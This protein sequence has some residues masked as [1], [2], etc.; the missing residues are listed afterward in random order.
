MKKGVYLIL[1]LLVCFWLT[2]PVAAE[3]GCS[4]TLSL[5]VGELPVT[6]GSFTLY[7]V[8]SESS[9]GYRIREE[10]GGGFVREEDAL[11]PHLAQWMERY[12]GEGGVTKLLDVDGDAVFSDLEEGLYLLVQRE[13][14]DGFYPIQSF[15]LTLPSD[16]RRN[17]NV[18]L[19]PL[20]RVMAA[21]ATG[22]DP[23]PYIGLAGMG[24]SLVGLVFCSGGLKRRKSGS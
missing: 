8:G 18:N 5:N 1:G 6:N 21:P 7:R 13:L 24:L 12:A 19:E 17:V 23:A 4:I 10:F 22:Q 20:P 3:N 14:T 11:S 9:D 2:V 16:G 15:L